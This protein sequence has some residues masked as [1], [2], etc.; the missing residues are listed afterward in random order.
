MIY[1][2]PQGP[3]CS[4]SRCI[5][6]HSPPGL[7]Q[8]SHIDLIFLLQWFKLMHDPGTMHR[9]FLL[10]SCSS[11]EAHMAAPYNDGAQVQVTSSEISPLILQCEVRPSPCDPLVHCL[12]FIVFIITYLNCGITF[13]FPPVEYVPWVHGQD[14][15]VYILFPLPH[16][17]ACIRQSI[18]ICYEWLN[19]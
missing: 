12:I 15:F 9:P 19:N 4:P 8:S 17:M 10:P 18:N 3:A 7:M 5:L 6:G 2:V 16:G 13:F 14:S 1:E 11:P